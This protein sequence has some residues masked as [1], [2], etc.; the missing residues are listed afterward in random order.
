M[1]CGKSAVAGMLEQAGFR[2]LDSDALVRNQVLKL[3]DVVAQVR[4]R[5]G[6]EVVAADGS[7]ERSRLAQRVFGKEE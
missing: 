6:E 4:E 3:P 7:V 2:R 5:F 1:G